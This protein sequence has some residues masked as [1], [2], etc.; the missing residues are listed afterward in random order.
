MLKPL[1]PRLL[2]HLLAQ[3]SWAAPLLQPFGGKH[4]RL[5]LPPFSATITVLEDGGLAL[6][7]ETASA[8]ATITVPPSVALRLL[9]GDEA[10]GAA[11]SVTGDTEFA[12]ALAKV[13]QGISWEYEE[14]LSRMV[15][16]APAHEIARFGRAA[17]NEARR[18]TLSVAGMFAEYW[19]EEQPLIA[20]KRHV[21]QFVRD[22]DTLREDAERLQKRIEKLKTRLQADH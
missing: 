17:V 12:S 5:I 19:Q 21:E 8:D 9:A 4:A 20:K 2:N 10:A 11:A 3:N 13:L 16:D 6:A 18:K 1:L 14:D 7:G 22:V 15:G